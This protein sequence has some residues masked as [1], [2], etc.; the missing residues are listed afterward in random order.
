MSFMHKPKYFT[1]RRMAELAILSM[2][3][4]IYAGITDAGGA[5]GEVQITNQLVTPVSMNVAGLSYVSDTGNAKDFIINIPEADL[6]K[7]AKIKQNAAYQAEVAANRP[8]LIPVAY[9]DICLDSNLK[10]F[11][12]QSLK[13]KAEI[14]DYNDGTNTISTYVLLKGNGAATNPGTAKE[15]ILVGTGAANVKRSINTTRIVPDTNVLGNG[16]DSDPISD[17]DDKIWPYTTDINS[18]L[19]RTT[20]NT[21]VNFDH[22]SAV[23]THGLAK[24]AY[25]NDTHA[26]GEAFK[27]DGSKYQA[28]QC[29]TGNAGV[30]KAVVYLDIV[31][32]LN[33]P[34]GTYNGGVTFNFSYG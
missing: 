19:T 26:A 20:S 9:F 23:K 5:T 10:D 33:N 1:L 24:I 18:N 11:S 4:P 14:T 3:S 7:L 28:D 34:A 30:V 31:S 2:L 32:V 16:F 13:A 17:A 27:V 15:Y 6:Q 12:S 22:Y 29:G 21:L 25:D 8:V